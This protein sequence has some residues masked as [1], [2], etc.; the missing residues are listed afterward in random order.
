MGSLVYSLIKKCGVI[1]HK[2]DDEI[3]MRF[4]N[5]S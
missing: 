2:I 1:K 4:N 5:V 3:S